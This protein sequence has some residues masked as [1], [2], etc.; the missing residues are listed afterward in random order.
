M[1]RKKDRRSNRAIAIDKSLQASVTYP[2]TPK[3]IEQWMKAKGNSDLQGYDTSKKTRTKAK[4]SRT[5]SV[6]TI[7]ELMDN[8]LYDYQ[9]MG[10]SSLS[11]SENKD[12][13]RK[14]MKNF[15]R[16]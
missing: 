16:Y 6:R 7:N 1:N 4:I 5:H 12:N 2:N 9:S 8:D 15:M 10:D 13:I 3:G 14:Q 11:K